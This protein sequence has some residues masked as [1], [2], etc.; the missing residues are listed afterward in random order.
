[1]AAVWGTGMM[2]GGGS[3]LLDDPLERWT[4]EQDGVQAQIAETV[5]TRRLAM[6]KWQNEPVLF[7]RDVLGLEC[8]PWQSD[9]L[10]A[11]MVHDNVAVRACHGVG[12]TAIMA[13]AFL[14]FTANHEGA[15]VPTTAPTFNKQ[16][17]DI[18][19]AEAHLRWQEARTRAPWF[20]DQFNISVTRFCSKDFSQTWFAVGIPSS[21]PIKAEGYHSPYLLAVVDEAKGVKKT[22]FEAIEGMRTTQKAKLL[23]GSTPGGPLGQFYDICVDRKYRSTWKTMFVIHPEALRGFLRRKETGLERRP[24]TSGGRYYS[25]RVR[26]EWVEARRAEW[27]EESPVFIARCVGDFPQ[28]AGDSLIPKGWIDDAEAREDGVNGAP[29]VSCDVA[30]YGRDRTV[31][32]GGVGGTV[33]HGEAIARTAGETTDPALAEDVGPDPT[34]P[35]YRSIVATAERCVLMRRKITALTNS[36][37]VPIVIDDTGLAGVADLLREQG[38][39]VIPISFGARPTDVPRD[40]DERARRQRRH[41]LDSKYANIKSEMGWDARTAFETGAIALGRLPETLLE[42]LTDQCTMM[43]YEIDSNGRLRIIDPDEQDEY[44]AAA[45]LAEGKKSPDHFHSLMLYCFVALE[46]GGQIAPHAGPK[47]P[48]GVKNIGGGTVL[49]I[50]RKPAGQAAWVTRRLG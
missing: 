44:A 22:F 23:V 42:P 16:V 19:W 18:L 2:R 17:R 35:R 49:P 3:A 6:R 5:D 27:G 46:F 34:R 15:R 7:S 8:D 39:W 11:V 9:V 10:D 47:L 48:K 24:N 50:N 4:S 32:Y 41:L 29:C 20:A 36:P 38:E 45:G 21:E 25:E 12:K 43:K 30:R 31:I 1:M 26:P 33:M 13:S 28:V 40:A 37:R 14:W